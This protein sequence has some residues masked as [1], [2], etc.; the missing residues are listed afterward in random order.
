M[1]ILPDRL[2]RELADKKK[3]ASDDFIKNKIL[4]VAHTYYSKM[5]DVKE[6]WI[7]FAGKRDLKS[8][9]INVYIEATDRA[10]KHKIDVPMQ[11]AQ[12]WYTNQTTGEVRPEWI[13]PLSRPKSKD[14]LERVTEGNPLLKSYFKNA[15]ERI[16]YDILTGAKV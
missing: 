1:L 4:E 11:G 3:V 7:L 9:K 2:N 15:S 12:L 16:G 14:S 5:K 13:L 6:L 8:N 10:N